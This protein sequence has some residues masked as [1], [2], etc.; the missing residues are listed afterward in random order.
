[1]IKG[2]VFSGVIGELVAGRWQDPKTGQRRAIP[3]KDIVIANTL[4]GSEAGLVQRLHPGKSIIVVSDERTRGVLGE[5]VF[6]ALQPLGNVKEFVWERPRITPEG[7]DELTEGTRD[8][9]ALIAVCS[10]TISDSVK[11]NT[12]LTH[13]SNLWFSWLR[14]KGRQRSPRPARAK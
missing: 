12:F 4:E 11:Y 7:M 1:M 5:R 13:V 2:R 9:E 14:F 6:R 8:A 10:G 3:V